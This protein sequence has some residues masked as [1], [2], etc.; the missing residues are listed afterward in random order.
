LFGDGYRDGRSGG[1]KVE[2]EALLKE[3]GVA[4]GRRRGLTKTGRG[5]EEKDERGEEGSWAQHGDR[6]VVTEGGE[7]RVGYLREEG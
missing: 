5:E 2:E 3:R 6:S 4:R 1:I 7:G